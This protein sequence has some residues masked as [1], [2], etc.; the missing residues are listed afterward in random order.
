MKALEAV[1]IRSE[2]QRTLDEPCKSAEGGKLR[3]FG[4]GSKTLKGMIAPLK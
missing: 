1:I 3:R 4:T 2:P